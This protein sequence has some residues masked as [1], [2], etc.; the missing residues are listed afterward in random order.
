MSSFSEGVGRRNIRGAINSILM[1]LSGNLIKGTEERRVLARDLAHTIKDITHGRYTDYEQPAASA[2]KL[3]LASALEKWGNAMLIPAKQVMSGIAG[4]RA[5]SFRFFLSDNLNNLVDLRE[6]MKDTKIDPEDRNYDKVL[7]GYMREAK[8]AKFNLNLVKYVLNSGLL[9]KKT[10]LLGMRSPS[11]EMF[12]DISRKEG[13]DYY[14]TTK[15]MEYINRQD[16]WAADSEAYK[17]GLNILTSIRQAEKM[18]IEEVLVSP[19][20]FDITTG[21]R[22][23]DGSTS[24]G[25]FEAIWEVFRRYPMLF[26]SQHV[27][28]KS[29]GFHPMKYAFNLFGLLFLDTLYMM[30]LRISAGQR[31]DDLIDE[32]EERPMNTL[33][34]YGVRLPVLGRTIALASQGILRAAEGF[35]GN[36]QNM[37]IAASAAEVI[38]KDLYRGVTTLGGLAFG[39]KTTVYGQDLLALAKHIPVL[40]ETWGR[41][42]GYLMM[43]HV[44]APD[45][46]KPVTNWFSSRMDLRRS[47]RGSNKGY[48][49]GIPPVTAGYFWETMIHQF[50]REMFPDIEH[51][52]EFSRDIVAPPRE[53]PQ[54]P[55][56][57]TGIVPETLVRTKDPLATLKDQAPY[58]KLPEALESLID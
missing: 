5:I 48:H 47:S 25:P 55:V 8:I 24:Q 13:R 29:T 32:W 43:D 46:A 38:A 28:R 17:Q 4:S 7:L 33:I 10:N 39:S 18:F 2:Q 19:N 36:S 58:T 6:S 16:E 11:I 31:Y 41:G 34:N 54:Q 57:A 45:I 56:T 42:L 49:H 37:F 9:S 44:E 22:T 14:S 40:G 21:H 23:A 27:V 1:P 3:F 52:S 20:A 30:L 51:V 35:K 15:L 12:L 26:V 53:I 50:G